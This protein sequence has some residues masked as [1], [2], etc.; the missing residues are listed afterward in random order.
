M[1]SAKK[2]VLI[3]GSIFLLSGCIEE[4]ESLGFDP[5]SYRISG[6]ICTDSAGYE[7]I[8]SFRY[9]E[10]ENRLYSMDVMEKDTNSTYVYFGLESTYIKYPEDTYPDYIIRV[11]RNIADEEGYLSDEINTEIV[12]NGNLRITDS[13]STTIDDST[14][15]RNTEYF[16][17]GSGNLVESHHTL[18]TPWSNNDTRNVYE[19]LNGHV[20]GFTSYKRNMLHEW[21][22]NMK[23]VFQ[24]S[25][26][27]LDEYTVMTKSTDAWLDKSR[28]VY[29]YN[30]SNVASISTYVKEGSNDW[31]LLQTE[32]FAYDSLGYLAADSVTRG[33]FTHKRKMY[34]SKGQGNAEQILVNP[35]DQL[36][37][38]PHIK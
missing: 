37:R 33:E 7:T 9:N 16:Y 10:I 22:E 2:L 27:N 13:E 34:Y 18:I 24:Y 32:G 23:T 15:I 3:L 4:Y 28:K 20:S 38:K 19:Y 35:I 29:A 11:N 30:G 17:D 36:F 8:Q 5:N 6:I 31:V 21:V 1:L 25:G 12:I 26:D 14:N